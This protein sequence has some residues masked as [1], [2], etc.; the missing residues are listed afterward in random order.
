VSGRGKESILYGYILMEGPLLMVYQ[1]AT[2]IICRYLRE[3]NKEYQYK[4]ITIPVG[5]TI[6]VAPFLLHKDPQYWEDPEKFDPLRYLKLS[7]VCSAV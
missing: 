6:V 5:C 3:C 4:E 1:C 2:L 7:I